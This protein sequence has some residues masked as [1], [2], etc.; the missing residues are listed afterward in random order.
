MKSA[1]LT[2]VFPILLT[3]LVILLSAKSGVIINNGLEELTEKHS[4]ALLLLQQMEADALQG[5]G[6]AYSYPV[7]NVELEK[8][9][10]YAL[11]ADFD[12]SA[13][14]FQLIASQQDEETES[15]SEAFE[16]IL[17]TKAE[18]LTSAE[19][20]FA[21]Y[22]R[23]GVTTSQTVNAFETSV[24]NMTE[25]FTE[26]VA[27]QKLE[28]DEHVEEVEQIVLLNIGVLILISTLLLILLI[29]DNKMKSE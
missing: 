20:M 26:L 10:F 2:R 14:A 16:H 25:A 9:E 3:I 17:T 4:P 12:T 11:M 19:A 27:V 15:E 7:L 24:D 22:E 21:D 6:E 23:L 28:L 18:L 29:K 8:E 5:V 13:I 1:R